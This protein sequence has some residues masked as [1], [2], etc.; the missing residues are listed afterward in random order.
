V[1]IF[2]I[3]YRQR[4]LQFALSDIY[5]YL[6]AF[7]A[8]FLLQLAWGAEPLHFWQVIDRFTGAS[9][10]TVSSTMLMLYLFDGYQRRADYR[11]G[12]YH[13]R[14]WASVI[15]SQ[16]MALVA[17]GLFPRGWWGPELGLA[18]GLALAVFLSVTRYLVCWAAPE[19]SFTT[20]VIV[21][22]NGRAAELA[23]D[24]ARVDSECELL[25]FVSPPNG[26]PRRRQSD[27][28][29][30]DLPDGA[31]P[32]EPKLGSLAD[33][34]AIA[35]KH[36]A[37]LV[38]VAHRA[39]LPGHLTRA[40][41]ECKTRGATIE[42]MPTFYKRLMGKL[43]VFHVSDS[44]LVYGPVFYQR[45]RIAMALRRIAD[46]AFVLFLG[47]PALPVMAVAAVLIRLESKGSPIYVQERLGRNKKPFPIYKLR[48][49]RL[50]AEEGTG[51]VWSQGKDD[52]RVTR[53]G[54]ILR[55][56]RI[57]ELPQLW[58]VLLGHMSVVGPRPEREHF[59]NRL[60]QSIPFYALRFSVKPGLSGWAQV[61]YRYGNT[62]EDAV[63][64][65]RFELYEIQE[66][67]P[68]LY[69]LIILKTVQT[70]LMRPG[71]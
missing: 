67:S 26:H 69:L 7:E 29:E 19:P 68:A 48:T 21:V 53:I 63:E 20:R 32:L 9:L 6:L 52:P 62:E 39:N 54:R 38:V 43:P 33:L 22:G 37:E 27:F 55:R 49:M 1:R 58:N 15:C 44:W 31:A 13:L 23:A 28:I 10:F 40:L 71:S 70:V 30:D 8:G 3:D 4:H 36:Q 66:L 34:P 41:L 2:G 16:L 25:G 57:D 35:T 60:E 51:A 17:Y 24:V 59:V 18:T 14:L 50:D 56:T 47:L 5:A 46:V 42:E 12:Y 61:N 11:R 64:K 65:L 45:N